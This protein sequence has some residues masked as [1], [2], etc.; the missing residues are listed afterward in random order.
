MNNSVFKKNI[1]I[2]L[3][4]AILVC[5]CQSTKNNLGYAGTKNSKIY[6]QEADIN[7]S[8]ALLKSGVEYLQKG[9]IDK[10]QAIFN[11]GLKFDLNNPALHFF[12]AYT[13][14][15]KFEKGDA[16]SFVTAEAVS[17]LA[18]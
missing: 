4:S 9:E 13:Y 10:A 12:N 15:L 3:L 1:P 6:S 16:D 11:T 14:Q 5:G 17:S 8:Q 2:T 18:K 7:R